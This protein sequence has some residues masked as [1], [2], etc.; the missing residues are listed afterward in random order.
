MEIS[1][2]RIRPGDK[3]ARL[4]PGGRLVR[5]LRG[6]HMTLMTLPD[7][8]HAIALGSVRPTS[9]SRNLPVPRVD[10]R[11]ARWGAECSTAESAFRLVAASP[12]A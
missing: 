8:P 1:L 9:A 2:R 11:P 7:T 4:S 12:E 3:P 10:H 5:W 6:H